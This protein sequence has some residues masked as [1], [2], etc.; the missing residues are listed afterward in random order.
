[1]AWY[2][3]ENMGDFQRWNDIIKTKSA[4]G[5]GRNHALNYLT[6]HVLQ[7]STCELFKKVQNIEN[8]HHERHAFVHIDKLKLKSTIDVR[9]AKNKVQNTNC[10]N[11]NPPCLPS[12]LFLLCS[13]HAPF[14]PIC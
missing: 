4:F 11:Q 3:L 5:D 10:R 12:V 14:I 2:L 6:L 1:M 9:F 13:H 8:I 7:I